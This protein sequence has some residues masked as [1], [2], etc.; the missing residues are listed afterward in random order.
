MVTIA[1]L[2]SIW[3]ICLQATLD[4]KGLS[5]SHL[6][7][8]T[9][10]ILTPLKKCIVYMCLI[11]TGGKKALPYMYMYNEIKI[12]QNTCTVYS[13]LLQITESTSV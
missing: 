13:P 8:E 3:P 12:K 5:A 4:E 7:L 2:S 9:L 6:S 11:L 1:I 10:Q